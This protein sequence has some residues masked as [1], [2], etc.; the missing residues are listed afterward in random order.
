MSTAYQVKRSE[1]LAVKDIEVVFDGTSSN[2]D[3]T[4]DNDELY[5]KTII[6]T[7]T[8]RETSSGT[9][10]TLGQMTADCVGEESCAY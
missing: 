4:D 9:Q 7:I 6:A 1:L 8:G 2:N 3:I 10:V 5:L